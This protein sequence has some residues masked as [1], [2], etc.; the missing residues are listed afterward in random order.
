MYKYELYIKSV[1]GFK[2]FVLVVRSL[3]WSVCVFAVLADWFYV[4]VTKLHSFVSPTRFTTTS[5]LIL[6]VFLFFCSCLFGYEMLKSSDCAKHLEKT[7]MKTRR[8]AGGN[9]RSDWLPQ[10][11]IIILLLRVHKNPADLWPLPPCHRL[12]RPLIGR[13]TPVP[14]L[15]F[16][17][18]LQWSLHEGQSF[19]LCEA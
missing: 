16:F 13:A 11:P 7:Q 19:N 1:Y 5:L 12:I 8:L 17:I 18:C 2:C 4:Q 10:P 9:W 14:R 15:Y 6:F 3:K